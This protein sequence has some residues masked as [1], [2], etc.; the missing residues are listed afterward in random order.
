MNYR[1][2]LYILFNLDI[3][4]NLESDLQHELLYELDLDLSELSEEKNIIGDKLILALELLYELCKFKANEIKKKLEIIL[5]VENQNYSFLAPKDREILESIDL[6]DFAMENRFIEN[7]FGENKTS[8]KLIDEY[9]SE[10]NRFIK[11]QHEQYENLTELY[12][13]LYAMRKKCLDTML[14]ENNLN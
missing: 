12:E 13:N 9:I 2:N 10:S 1:K 14:L 7:I 4:S 11:L 8:M 3:F 6:P 5:Q